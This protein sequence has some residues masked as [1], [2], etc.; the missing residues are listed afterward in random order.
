VKLGPT[1]AGTL[2]C[3]LAFAAADTPADVAPQG[4][5]GAI[6]VSPQG[7]RMLVG[8]DGARPGS[9]LFLSDDHGTSWQKAR[10]VAGAAGVT[11][12]AFAPSRPSVAY[13]AVITRRSG[14]LASGFFASG[15][16]GASWHATAWKQTVGIFG[17]QLPAAVDTIVVDPDQPR[18]VYAVTHGVLRRSL[19]GGAS[20]AVARAGLP[21]TLDITSSRTQQL[22][23]GRGGALYYATGR[24]SGPGQVYRSVDRASSWQPA[25]R[26][27][28]AAMPGWALLALAGDSTR[29]SVVYAATGKGLY[30]TTNSGRS[31]TRSLADPSTAVATATE[32]GRPVVVLASRS[33][34][35][36]RI[37]AQAAW[38]SLGGPPGGLSLFTLDPASADRIYGAAYTQNDATLSTCATLWASLNAGMTWRSVGAALPLARKN[39]AWRPGS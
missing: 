27:L 13:A 20:W 12:L 15:D 30:A 29:A 2:A 22:A 9:W 10:G 14:H 8:I 33:G 37:G 11:A 3:V 34:L 23:A 1:L 31:W 38:K 24:L 36:E 28:P 18:T 17:R 5:V 6:A 19:N 26:G 32:A 7:G 35:V 21:A 25:G 39:C 4:A 16:G